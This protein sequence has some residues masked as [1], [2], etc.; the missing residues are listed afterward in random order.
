[1]H[2]LFCAHQKKETFAASLPPPPYYF[3]SASPTTPHI[4]Q[5]ACTR[6]VC[7]YCLPFVV[8][9][10]VRNILN[11]EHAFMHPLCTRSHSLLL[12][13]PYICHANHTHTSYMHTHACIVPQANGSENVIM[14]TH[15]VLCFVFVRHS[16][17]FSLLV[18][19]IP[20]R[21]YD[22]VSGFVQL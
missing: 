15:V 16:S 19:E 8:C 10:Y 2:S 21:S 6:I 20:V 14:R 5:H 22:S 4:I 13:G 18:V 12:P 11:L 1:M 3:V 7:T 9:T 17:F